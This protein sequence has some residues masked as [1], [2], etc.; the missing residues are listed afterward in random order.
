MRVTIKGWTICVA[1]MLLLLVVPPGALAQGTFATLTGTVS[2]GGTA[3]AAATVTIDSEVL[4]NT[5]ETR[6]GPNG[7]Y[8]FGALPPGAYDVTIA[9]PGMQSMTRKAELRLGEV[10]RVDAALQPSAEG[11]TVT[12]TAL[13]RS[14]LERP[15]LDSHLDY[16]TV[17]ALPIG[18]DLSERLQLS[19]GV[20]GATIHG[21]ALESALVDGARERLIPPL[22]GVGFSGFSDL[23][24]ADAVQES[25]VLTSNAPA[26]YGRVDG[27]VVAALT[28][29]G[30]NQLGGSV[31]DTLSSERW[32]AGNG[33][34]SSRLDSRYEATLGGKIVRD[35]IWFFLAGESGR[36][37][38]RPDKQTWM[39]KITAAPA[40]NQSL[41]V[42]Y[43]RAADR[44]D[45][46]AAADYTLVAT[47][48]LVL[49][50][51]AGFF[52][53][54]IQRQ[55]AGGAR[56]YGWLP[57]RWGDHELT[58]GVDYE[59]DHVLVPSSARYEHDHAF[60]ASDDWRTS[61]WV[62]NAG[63]R[64]DRELGTSWRS[65]AAYDLDGSGGRRLSATFTQEP[66][67]FGYRSNEATLGYGQ[68]ITAN[69]FVQAAI[70]HSTR[71]GRKYRALEGEARGQYLIFTGGASLTAA[72]LGG[73][74]VTAA[75]TWITALPPGLEQH[76]TISALERLRSGAS[77]TDLALLYRF[78]HFAVAPFAKLDL[79]NVFDRALS[80]SAESELASLGETWDRRSVRVGV[81]AR[82]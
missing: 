44:D 49:N 7:T 5:R 19:P 39:A 18:R 47:S 10:S 34:R 45:S 8:W 22:T 71:F 52:D 64:H 48:A 29:S 12:V 28:R 58:A 9:A 76:F 27:G 78:S 30:S 50:G 37:A 67:S 53:E 15:Q 20:L 56:A 68:R 25:A 24:V 57:G 63:V 72:T 66:P 23:E 38:T 55:E 62:V 2:S 35:A 21:G 32:I 16:D 3:V 14:V 13:T 61:R 42:S 26:E 79:L 43:L 11:E 69:S 46:R 1:A 74:R 70:V 4:Q 6:V 65:G 60:F 31:R 82:F 59:H 80:R 33:S 73:A 41:V 51:R 81:G 54:S 77:S 40:A 75:N 17:E 36:A